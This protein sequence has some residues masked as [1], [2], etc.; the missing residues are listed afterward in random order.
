MPK[1]V[2]AQK[3]EGDQQVKKLNEVHMK[4]HQ[5]PDNRN[6]AVVLNKRVVGQVNNRLS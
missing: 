2:K 4:K 6:A 3:P 5:V 1:A